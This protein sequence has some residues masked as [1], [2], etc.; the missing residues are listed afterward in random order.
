MYETGRLNNTMWDC[1]YHLIW[2]PK[3]RRKLSYGQLRK[4]LGEVFKDLSI[5]KESGVVE[6]HLIPDHLF[7]CCSQFHKNIRLHK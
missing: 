2:I 3:Y 6:G 5:Q 4:C 7:I 1:K